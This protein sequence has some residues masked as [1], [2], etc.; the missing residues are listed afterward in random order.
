M[1]QVARTT[2]DLKVYRFNFQPKFVSILYKF[3]KVHQFDSCQDFKD[4]FSQWEEKHTA[5]IIA[6][7]EYLESLGYT[8]DFR[9]KVFKSARYY[10]RKK[11][12]GEELILDDG[13]IEDEGTSAQVLAKPPIKK[14][15]PRKKYTSIDFD[16]ST[17]I[18]EYLEENHGLKPSEA[19]ELFC[20][21]FRQEVDDEVC[22]LEREGEGEDNNVLLKIKKTFKNKHFNKKREL[23]QRRNV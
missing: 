10:F 1:S 15:G 21:M 16:L 14:S 12:G 19:F 8:G 11:S 2:P 23:L 18:A 4:A 7:T 5:D 22:R 9:T 6:E 20:E 13:D 17:K 3:S